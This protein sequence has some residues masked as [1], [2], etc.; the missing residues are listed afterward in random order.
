[1]SYRSSIDASVLSSGH[2]ISFTS[3]VESFAESLGLGGLVTANDIGDGLHLL[4]LEL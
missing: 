3:N 1:M 4:G 2:N